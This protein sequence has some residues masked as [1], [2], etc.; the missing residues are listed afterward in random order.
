MY[1][2]C[3]PTDIST[4]TGVITE[5][6]LETNMLP[7]AKSYIFKKLRVCHYVT[8]GLQISVLAFLLTVHGESRI[9]YH[10]KRWLLILG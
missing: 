9:K 5:T 4:S 2:A 3:A 10:E 7:I 8:I 6:L 1:R